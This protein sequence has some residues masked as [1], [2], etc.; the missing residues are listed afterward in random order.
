MC[1][2]NIKEELCYWKENF[3]F[4]IGQKRYFL[5]QIQSYP[6]LKADAVFSSEV[7]YLAVCSVKQVKSRCPILST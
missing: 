3:S 6:R 1:I 4:L 2:F 5:L 7:E